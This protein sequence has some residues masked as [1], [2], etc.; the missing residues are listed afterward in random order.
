V[1][2]AQVVVDAR[3]GLGEDLGDGVEAEL[4][5][6]VEQD[7]PQPLEVGARVEPVSGVASSCRPE[8]ADRVVVVQGPHRHA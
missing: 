7:P 3:V 2:A 5:L 1:L 8:Q 4:E 6:A